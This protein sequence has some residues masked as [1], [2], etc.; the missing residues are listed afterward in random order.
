V[1]VAIE[2]RGLAMNIRKAVITAA[3][4]DQRSLTLQTLV[5]RD[6][7]KTALQIIL[8]EVASAG[9]DRACLVIMPGDQE[10]YARRQGARTPPPVRRTA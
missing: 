10:T 2:G 7:E 6:G 1:S 4:R 5:D 3:G 9:I 8:D